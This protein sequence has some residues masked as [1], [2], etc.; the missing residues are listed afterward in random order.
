MSDDATTTE[1]IVLEPVVNEARLTAYAEAHKTKH[2]WDHAAGALEAM[3]RLSE[4]IEAIEDHT[5]ITAHADRYARLAR[6]VRD[7]HIEASNTYMGFFG[8]S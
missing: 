3:A 7:A 6:A 1:Y 2:P 5:P 8:G 4:A